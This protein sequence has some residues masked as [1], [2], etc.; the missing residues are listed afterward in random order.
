MFFQLFNLMMENAPSQY[1]IINKPKPA[2]WLGYE[3]LETK[4]A[5]QAEEKYLNGRLKMMTFLKKQEVGFRAIIDGQ[6][7]LRSMDG[8]FVK[9][10]YP[11]SGFKG[12]AIR[13]TELY[14]PP[15]LKKYTT[16][17][18]KN[19]TEDTDPVTVHGEPDNYFVRDGHH[20]MEAYKKAGRTE[21]PV[22]IELES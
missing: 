1:E 2:P 22:W 15:T 5:R 19:P 9:K 11:L 17:L 14:S 21:V 16:Y 10:N 3:P 20:R 6:E 18:K 4:Q 13:Q 8:I 7:Y 12:S